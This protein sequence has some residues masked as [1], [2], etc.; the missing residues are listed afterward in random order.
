MNS[1][2]NIFIPKN[3]NLKSL[4]W[5]FSLLCISFSPLLFNFIWG[6]HDWAS[7]S[8]YNTI[9]SGMIEG[10]IT[11]YIFAV[12]LLDGKII[13]ILNTTL[14]FF[15]YCLSLTILSKYF[16]QFNTQ[17]AKYPLIIST[18]ATL[19]YIN[20]IIYFQFIVLSQL[21]WPFIISISLVFA[22]KAKQ[23]SY[24]LNTFLSTILL[25]TSI[26]G[27][28]A[29]GNLYITGS[30]LYAIQLN[31]TEINIKKTLKNLSPFIISFVISYT[32]LYFAYNYMLTNAII[33]TSYNNSTLPLLEILKKLPFIL[34]TS[35]LSLLQTQPFFPFSFKVITF[36]LIMYFSI[37]YI[38]SFSSTKNHILSA[39]LILFLLIGIKYSALLTNEAAEDYFSQKDPIG[40]AIRTDFFSIPLLLLYILSTLFGSSKK[41]NQNLCLL[42]CSILLFIN[43]N[44]NLHYSKVQLFGFKAEINLL[45]RII[46]RI[47]SSPNF[48]QNNLYSVTQ[49]G[50]ISLRKKYYTPSKYEKYGF[51]TL[52]TAFTRYWLTPDFYNF[53]EPFRF[54]SSSQGIN[55]ADISPKMIDFMSY[56]TPLWP[57]P[58]S[59]YI[60]DK[61]IIILTAP[62]EKNTMVLQ[63]K[64]IQQGLNQ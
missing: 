34:K 23:S 39:L 1:A 60:D 62:K 38:C 31:T 53:Y 50:E 59:T 43:I 45:E 28:P 57:H 49:T 25:L 35:I 46:N 2:K 22:K 44:S 36:A 58:S 9:F 10:R 27:Y 63:L 48:N 19:P 52:H 56:K 15:F 61:Y 29:C 3:Y 12:P 18:I 8:T 40:F 41:F 33:N 32:I 11:Q 26:S 30:I 16:F 14:G 54:A 51:Y 47:T 6:N 55:P 17:N 7:I 37:S 20:E 13:P 5:A 4:F 24:I 64:K 42:A 21:I